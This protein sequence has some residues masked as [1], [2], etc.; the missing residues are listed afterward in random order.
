MDLSGSMKRDYYGNYSG[1]PQNERRIAYAKMALQAFTDLLYANLDVKTFYG[2]AGFKN[3]VPG[4]NP[5]D[6][7]ALEYHPMSDCNIVGKDGIINIIIPNNL[8]TGFGTP[9]LAGLSTAMNMFQ[10]IDN[11]EKKVIV[12]LSD[13]AHNCPSVISDLTNDVPY[14]DLIDQIV[15][16]N[17]KVYTIAFGQ[18]GEVDLDLLENIASGT[19]GKF[20]DLTDGTSTLVKNAL[21]PTTLDADEW[22]DEIY[23]DGD[24]WT[25]GNALDI[26][27][28]DV[29]KDE[30]GLSYS[31]EPM[32]IIDQGVTKQF[33]I[34]VSGLES[35]ICFFISWAT[36]QQNYLGVKIKTSVGNVLPLSH[37]GIQYIHHDNYTI[38]TVSGN[39]LNQ[40]GVVSS[41]PWK[42]EIDASN[43]NNE[44]EKFQYL[45]LNR[46]KKLKFNAWFDKEWYY[47]GD[48]MKIYMELLFENQHL[49]KLNKVFIIGSMPEEGLGNWLNKEEMSNQRLEERRKY[50]IDRIK[51]YTQEEAS[52]LNLDKMQKEKLFE[53]NI[54]AML[55]DMT[56]TQ[57]KFQIMT[58]EMKIKYP[59]RVIIDGLVFSDEG[60]NGDETAGDGIYTAVYKNLT[61]EGTYKFNI[62][63]ID[64][65]KVKNIKREAQLQKYVRVKIKPQKFIKDLIRIDSLIKGKLVYKVSFK[66]KDEYDNIPHPNSLRNIHLNLDKGELIGHIQANPDGTF[67]QMVS[68]T[69]NVKPSQVKMTM[70]VYDQIGEQRLESLIPKW[71]YLIIGIVVLIIIG[72]IRR[73]K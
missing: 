45:V 35:K 17:I 71:I 54:S 70:N 72:L 51:N 20:Y 5:E 9:L 13:G 24:A 58:E 47:T 50:E 11:N 1:V 3:E 69:E 41:N 6:C 7:E 19:S 14:N 43:I 15:E 67:T 61:K 40:P 42:L 22:E 64:N 62:T 29:L 38:I 55:E 18:S 39:Y 31:D 53:R 36:S 59:G 2:I 8:N 28:S 37:P 68:L 30:L 63:V 66:L 52:K 49:T 33:N 48:I 46:S 26:A 21:D 65:S 4:T 34:P 73:K 44:P 60:K 23:A 16:K 56:S 57:L 25:P 10:T 12:L 32:D 27:Y